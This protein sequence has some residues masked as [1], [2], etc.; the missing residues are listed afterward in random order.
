MSLQWLS[1]LCNTAVSLQICQQ[2]CTWYDKIVLF[3]RLS[4]A[5]LLIL[6]SNLRFTLKIALK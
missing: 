6:M 5:M 4:L 1:F 2:L 3:C